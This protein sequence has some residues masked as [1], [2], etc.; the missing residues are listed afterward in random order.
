MDPDAGTTSPAESAGPGTDA[1]DSSR[2]GR[3]GRRGRLF[4][5]SI[6][7][8][9]VPGVA[10]ATCHL[11]RGLSDPV[12]I[13]CWS[14]GVVALLSCTYGFARDSRFRRLPA[15][16]GRIVA[17]VSAHELNANDLH[18][19]IWSI[20][21]QRGPV[22]GE[23][24]VID[25]G[26]VRR[27]VQPFSHSRVRWHR[28]EN[29]GRPA[30]EVYVLDRLDPDDWD[31]VL[32]VDGSSTLDSHAVEHQLR[33]LSLPHVTAAIGMPIARNVRQNLFTRIEDLH[34]GTSAAMWVSRPLPDTV[35]LPPTGPA[36]YRASAIFRSRRRNSIANDRGDDRCL[37]VL[38]ARE[39]ELVG[40]RATT[41]WIRVPVDGES[42]YRQWLR[43]SETWWSLIPL[44][45][46]GAGWSR[47]VLSRLI[48]PARMATASLTIGYASIILTAGAGRGGL[49]W[50]PI[51]LFPALYLLVRYVK[52]GRYLIGRQATSS[53]GKLWTWLLLTPVEVLAN[54]LFFAPIRGIALVRLC[55]VWWEARCDDHGPSRSAMPWTERGTIYYS[56]HLFEGNR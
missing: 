31:F 11:Y 18:A 14:V 3:A 27:P 44:V 34:I 37:A 13:A 26:S 42:A 4:F 21:N 51:A 50:Q 12:L 45:L 41:A 52:T 46:S 7:G 36:L 6:T 38:A 1:D 55:R 20:L 19:C 23:V 5:G 56:G 22:I 32:T 16:T 17:I 49:G 2:F 10:A 48:G 15:A 25:D 24:H 39:G 28:R 40:V 33:A 9:V 43:W 8:I 54:L 29:G 35:E 47:R 30:A 53:R